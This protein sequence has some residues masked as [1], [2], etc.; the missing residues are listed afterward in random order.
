MEIYLDTA[1]K[2]EVL[3]AAKFKFL[4]GITTNPSIIAKEKE[5]F[6]KVIQ[7]IDY[8]INGKIWCQVTEEEPESMYEQGMTM[9]KW[10]KHPVIK[11]PM[12]ENGLE[13]AYR[14]KQSGVEVNM[15][16]IYNYSQV[17]LAAKAGVD[18]ISPYLGRI[19]D[20]SNNGMEFIIKSKEIISAMNGNTKVIGASIRS[21]KVV[22]DLASAGV[23]AV[24]MQ[25]SIYTK[26]FISDLTLK[27]L[28]Q[29]KADWINKTTI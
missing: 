17:V 9:S 8:S 29:F 5:D 15:T 21:P 24:T 19:E 20:H 14:L 26:M 22:V 13:A 12:T 25:F 11:L 1:D 10:A 2:H 16:L 18:Y 3:Y 28:N 6:K 4:D 23:D 27:G 7:R